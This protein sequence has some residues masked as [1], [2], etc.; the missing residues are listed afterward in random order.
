MKLDILAFG[1]HPD[2]VELSCSGTLLREVAFGKKVGICDLTLGE[3]GTRGSAASRKKEAEHASKILHLS[4]RE[5][6]E[7]EDGF[8]HTDK[9][10]LLRALRVI[11]KYQPEIV[12]ANAIKDRHPD[13]GRASSFIS[14]ACFLS[15]LSKIHTSIN[16][17]EQHSWRPKAVY[18]YIQDRHIEPNF[19]VDITPFFDKKMEAIMAFESQFYK[20][21]ANE[22]ETPIS[23]KAFLDF[24]KAR[25]LSMGR[26]I[27][28]QYGEGFTSER[29]LG[30]SNL[31]DL[32]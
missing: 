29:P 13:H 25:A 32:F 2:D 7:L 21:G 9:Q 11:R 22:P 20:P 15:G 4:A 3:L 5:N 24:V 27:N 31:F 28:V 6:L 23:S 19:V 12:F 1:A 26:L 17:V 16:G 30:V 14:E 18:H 8:F 10:S